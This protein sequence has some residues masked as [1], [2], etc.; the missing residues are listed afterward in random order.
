MTKR[1]YDNHS[2][3]F[4]LWLRERGELDSAYGYIAT[5]LD[6]IWRNYNTG[7]WMLLEEKRHG[8]YLRRWQR[9]IFDMLDKL[10]RADPN[11]CGFHVLR[12]SQTSPD[13]GTIHLDGQEISTSQLLAFLR[14]EGLNA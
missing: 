13:D 10:A 4:G 12:F 8:A 2:T 1:R 9:E 6:Y 5:N 14:F 11:Y 7:K 3:E